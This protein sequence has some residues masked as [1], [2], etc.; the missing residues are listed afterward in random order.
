MDE[1]TKSSILRGCELARDLESRL[2]YLMSR[3][4]TVTSTCEEIARSFREAGERLTGTRSFGEGQAYSGGVRSLESLATRTN[5]IMRSATVLPG[6]EAGGDARAAAM[7]LSSDS[8]RGSASS[9]HRAPRRYVRI[10]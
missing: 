5:S 3:P 10:P 2:Q 6:V 7:A 9:S 8:S 4:D 1:V